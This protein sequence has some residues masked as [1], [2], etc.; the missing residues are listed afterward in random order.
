MVK[1]EKRS[2]AGIIVDILL[3]IDALFIAISM[4]ISRG[5]S[6]A[7]VRSHCDVT[8]LCNGVASI[9]QVMHVHNKNSNIQGKSL[10][11]IQVIFRTI[12]NY[13]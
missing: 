8:T 3:K 11:V 2:L 9:T 1:W 5:G 13:S 6:R 12:R 4:I 10:N 7:A